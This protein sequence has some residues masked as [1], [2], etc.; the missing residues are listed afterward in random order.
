MDLG[1]G[2]H[3]ITLTVDD[4]NG[5]TYVD[6]VYVSVVDTTPPSITPPPYITPEGDTTGGWTSDLGP[7]SAS[8]IVD[9]SPM[10]SNDAPAVFPLG[11]TTVT[12]TATDASGNSAIATQVVTVMDNTAPTI[13]PSADLSVEGNTEG[14]WTGDIGAASASDVVDD[15]LTI[16]NDAP[17]VFPVGDTTVTWTATD[18]SGNSATATQVVTVVDIEPPEITGLAA[19][20]GIFWPPDHRMHSV[21][22]TVDVLDTVDA[23][24]SCMIFEVTSNEPVSGKGHGNTSPDWVITGDLTVD[25]RAERSGKGDG[26]VY[27]VAV[28]CTDDSGNRSVSTVTVSVDHD[29]GDRKNT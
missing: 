24:P 10:I 2:T 13:A 22:V 12:W 7:A 19:D 28:A 27:T 17:S 1:L 20:P 6:T 14:G 21:T 9:E 5:E 29:Q 11:E 18:A 25:L 16:T 23:S 3:E 8:D 15:S 26:R 4:G